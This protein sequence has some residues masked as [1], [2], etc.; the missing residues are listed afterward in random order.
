MMKI[1]IS[2]MDTRL[3]CTFG[4]GKYLGAFGL[5]IRPINLEL[6][7]D[8]MFVSLHHK[9]IYIVFAHGLLL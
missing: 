1:T 6:M 2:F 9:K 8:Y 4:F 3:L 5:K 7:F